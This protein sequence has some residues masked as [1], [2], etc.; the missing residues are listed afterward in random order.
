MMKVKKVFLFLGI[1][2]MITQTPYTQTNS[3]LLNAIHVAMPFLT[4][5]SDSRGSG[6]GDVGVATSPDVYSMH[7]NPA[8]FV[9]AENNMGFSVSFTPWL[10]DLIDDINLGNLSYYT[11]LDQNQ[12]LGFSLSYF[13]LGVIYFSTLQGDPDGQFSPNEF[14]IDAAYSR[15]FSE[16]L[17]GGLAFRYMRSDLTGGYT[18]GGIKSRAAQAFAADVAVYYLKNINVADFPSKLSLGANVANIGNKVSYS[19][20]GEAQFIP[21]TL[22]LGSALSLELDAYNSIT[23]AADLNKLLVPT[24]PRIEDIDGEMV[25]VAGRSNNVSVAQGMLQSF[26][27]APGGF[28]EEL[29]EITF[30]LG[31]EYWYHKQ[32]ALRAGYFY[33]HETKGNRKFFTTGM[34]IRFNVFA[35]DFSYLI[36]IFRTN[37][38]A[39]TLRF[40]LA[41]DFEPAGSRS[42]PVTSSI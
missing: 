27:D 22:K 36:P 14:S 25:I 13:N 28:R 17:S 24:P 6:M 15:R 9:F 19:E 5:A 8:K 1:L 37:P 10:R 12:A 41:F 42:R 39:N 26:Y 31:A 23:F 30:G 34:G 35:I 7:Y 18:T 16:N 3:D 38:L 29:R 33:E 21:I 32:F 40:S 2:L 20:S 4:I 11:K